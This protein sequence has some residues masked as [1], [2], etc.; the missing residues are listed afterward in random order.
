MEPRLGQRGSDE[1]AEKEML[2]GI[3]KIVSECYK[4]ICSISNS[5]QIKT[6]GE[7]V[8]AH[9]EYRKSFDVFKHYLGQHMVKF[10]P[11]C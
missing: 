9:P 2:I 7:F 10:R 6:V 11:I 4:S 8:F 3:A 1:G 5:S